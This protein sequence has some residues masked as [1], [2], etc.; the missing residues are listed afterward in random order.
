MKSNRIERS[1]MAWIIVA[2]LLGIVARTILPYLQTLRE[3]PDTPF[4]RKFIVPAVIT[5]LIALITSPLVFATIPPEQLNAAPTFQSLIV[6]F[7]A[8][9]G[10]TDVVREGQKFVSK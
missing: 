6:L 10:A 5:V 4:N 7:A 3:N 2:V 1:I 9:W 8:G